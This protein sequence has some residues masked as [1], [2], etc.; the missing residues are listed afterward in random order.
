MSPTRVFPSFTEIRFGR[1]PVFHFQVI[2]SLTGGHFRRKEGQEKEGKER[3]GV[4]E[5]GG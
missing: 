3:V 5:G 2:G 4:G 1:N